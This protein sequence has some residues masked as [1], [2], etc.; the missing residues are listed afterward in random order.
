MNPTIKSLTCQE[1]NGVKYYL[2]KHKKGAGYFIRQEF[3]H[4][5]RMR[6]LHREV[7][8]HTHGEIPHKMDIHHKDGN[9]SNN[10]LENLECLT[11]SAH[12]QKHHDAYSP[13]QRAAVRKNLI[14]NAVPK[15]KAWH[16]SPEG[17]AWHRQH[18]INIGDRLWKKGRVQSERSRELRRQKRAAYFQTDEGK[19]LLVKMR[20][21]SIKNQQ[22]LREKR[23]AEG[24]FSRN[25]LKALRS[26]PG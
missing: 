10:A 22:R 2:C 8:S 21:A 25:E 6:L 14:D 20:D 9:T 1:F 19:A 24:K 26:Q 7:W 17:L 15:S 3:R 18:A 12:R 4:R 13:E 16:A 5:G 23:H 11:R